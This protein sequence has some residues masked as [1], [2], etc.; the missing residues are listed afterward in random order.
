MC[1]NER[2]GE[3]ERA[4]RCMR[5]RRSSS[6]RAKQTSTKARLSRPLPVVEGGRGEEEGGRGGGKCSSCR[7]R[8]EI[9]VRNFRS[10]LGWDGRRLLMGYTRTRVQTHTHTQQQTT[11]EEQVEEEEAVVLCVRCDDLLGRWIWPE[12]D[13]TEWTVSQKV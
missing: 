9:R 8:E 10:P 1:A 2:K 12:I 4:K 13:S 7:V 3:R 5:R 11:Q 6:S